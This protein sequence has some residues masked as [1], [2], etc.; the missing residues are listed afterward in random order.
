MIIAVPKPAGK[1]NK[2]RP[3]NTLLQHQVKRLWE[4][5]QQ[6]IPK[7]RTGIAIDPEKL[8]SMTE[9]E[10][11]EFIKRMTAKLHELGKKPKR[12]R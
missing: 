10:A 3:I 12:T 1:V 7:H 11:A 2:S 8:D 6:H 4:I 5:E 9:R